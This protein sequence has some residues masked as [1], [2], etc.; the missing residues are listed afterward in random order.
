MS[1]T[2]K[3]KKF[4]ITRFSCHLFTLMLL[5]FW[6]SLLSA[7]DIDPQVEQEINTDGESRVIISLHDPVPA[8]ASGEKR[9]KAV[10]FA[11]DEVLK[12]LVKGQFKKKH[13]YKQVPALAATIDLTAL[14]I[15]RTHP[16]VESVQADSLQ[17]VTLSYS[18][19]LIKAEQ[20]NQLIPTSYTGANVYI[21]VIDTGI[22]T[23]HPDLIDDLVAQKCFT[24]SACPPNNLSESDNAEDDQGH[25]TH[26]A[27]IITSTGIVAPQG[28]APDTKIIAIKVLDASGNG[29]SSDTIAALD[30]VTDHLATYPIK[31][32]NLSLG[33]GLYY[34]VCDYSNISYANAIKLLTAQG[35]TIFAA[36][37]NESSPIKISSPACL[38][39]T[40]AVGNTYKMSYASYGWSACTDDQNRAMVDKVACTSNSNSTLLDILAPGSKITSAGKGGGTANMGGTSMATPTAVGVAALMLEANPALSPTDILAIM[41][42]TGVPVVD[43]RNGATF[44]RIDAL[45]ATK[46]VIPPS[47]PLDVIATALSATEVHLSW[48]DN[49]DNEIFFSVE[50]P[51]GTSLVQIAGNEAGVGNVE[52]LDVNLTCGT[53]YHYTVKATNIYGGDSPESTVDVT[54]LPCTAGYDSTPQVGSEITF[55]AT[56]NTH[57]IQT[58]TVWEIGTT[59]LQISSVILSGQDANIFVVTPT[60]LT[61]AEGSDSQEIIIECDSSEVGT[62]RTTL[63]VYHNAITNPATYP[64]LCTINPAIPGYGSTPVAGSTINFT[65]VVS[66]VSPKQ[67]L[68]VQETGTATLE[69]S[70]ELGGTHPGKFIISPFSF[71]ILD[72]GTDQSIMIQCVSSESGTYTATLTIHHNTGDSSPAVYNLSCVV[73]PPPKA[74]Y[75]SVPVAGS[76]IQLTPSIPTKMSVRE[77]GNTTLNITSMT[78]SGNSSKFTITPNS[79]SVTDSGPAQTIIIQCYG[80]IPGNYQATLLIKHNASAIP[81]TYYLSCRVE[82]PPTPKY[83]SIPSSGRTLTFST[84]Q[85]VNANSY[86]RIQETGTAMLTISSMVLQG[87]HS[88]KFKILTPTR[89]DLLD[90]GSPQIVT[91]QCN[92]NEIGTYSTTLIVN[93][94]ATNSPAVYNLRCIVGRR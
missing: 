79:F 50:R 11:Q 41:K 42:G 86:L 4:S 73:A 23:D 10:K 45:A 46:A 28:I 65:T 27:G 61:I 71:N 36:S 30:W 89:F 85:G 47:P 68:T 83:S 14:E 57:A 76:I 94:N 63:T 15:L 7:A 92:A 2:I 22:D 53:S 8:D 59:A 80:N 75:S 82:P 58:L 29:R 74:G 35:V 93:H 70:V 77:T 25:G 1:A 34:S 39:N 90:G 55:N 38:S 64:L 17:S 9:T 32:V 26:V 62:Y 20:V 67:I 5:T 40:I 48:I 54:T 12:R 33:G 43:S 81:A 52:Y 13:Q 37:G 87:A 49:S 66:S 72:G 3:N 21:A 18:K 56:V 91:L 60:N 19:P 88:N 44:P 24:D 78:L 6:N 84:K 16:Q 69:V 31:I 51:T